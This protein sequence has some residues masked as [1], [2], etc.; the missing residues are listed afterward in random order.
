MDYLAISVGIVH[1]VIPGLKP[2]PLAIQRTIDIR[3]ATG[4]PLVLHGASGIPEGEVEAARAAGVHKFNADTDLRHVFRR[5]MLDVWSRGD[6][7]LEDAMAEGR[8]RMVAATIKEMK[9]YGCA[10]KARGRVSNPFGGP[11]RIV[12]QDLAGPREDMDCVRHSLEDVQSGGGALR[13]YRPKPT[14]AVSPRDTTHANYQRATNAL[15]ARGFTPVE[16]GAGGLLAVY[17]QAALIIDLIAPHNDPRVGEV[18]GEYCPGAYG[19]NAEGRVKLAGLA[20]R[21]KRRGYHLGVVMSVAR[22]DAARDAVAEAYDLPGMPFDPA[23]FG[24]VRD[25]VET[26]T[27]DSAS[28]LTGEVIISALSGGTISHQT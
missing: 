13:I 16:C 6:R 4:I 1:G 17:D 26:L 11:V 22:S 5:G 23:S 2:E 9:L 21:I 28:S 3:D 27:H 25:M 7:Q 8:K 15:A 18:K 24:A 12:A 20:Q 19:V 10:G 14:A